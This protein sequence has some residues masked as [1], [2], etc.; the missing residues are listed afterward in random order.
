MYL[1]HDFKLCQ[2]NEQTI[3]QLQC[4]R[5][6]MRNFE[7]IYITFMAI[8]KEEH[9]YLKIITILLKI[10]FFNNL[11]KNYLYYKLFATNFFNC[12]SF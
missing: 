4:E 7:N 12:N 11:L 3:Y 1:K 10:N 5:H 2:S 9:R 6:N 8:P